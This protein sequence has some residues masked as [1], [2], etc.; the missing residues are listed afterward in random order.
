MRQHLLTPVAAAALLLS[1]AATAVAAEATVAE[2][3]KSR[4]RQ[5]L[6]ALIA[7]KADVNAP[8]A[9]G[10]TA[11]HWAVYQ[12]D[13]AMVADL[14]AAGAGVNATNDYGVAPLSLACTNRNA[15]VV[16]K[17]LAAGADPNAASQTGETA[18]M[19]CAYSGSAE[20]VRSL[21]QRG[22]DVNRRENLEQ[23]T[24][25]MWA[26]SQGHGDVV[27]ILL[28]AGADLKARTRVREHFV[29]Y[30]TQCGN[31]GFSR[32]IDDAQ[33]R[34]SRGGYAALHFAARQGDVESARLLVDAGAPIEE[35]AADGYTPL[36]LATHS[37][38]ATLTK[39][40]LERGANPNASGTGY[41]ALHTAVLRGDVGIVNDLIAAGA[42]VRSK[43]ARPSPTERFTDRWMT[44]SLS[45]VGYTPVQL[46]ARYLEVDCVRALL[47]AGADP[48]AAAPDGLTPLMLV[49]GANMNRNGSTDR[50]GRTVD[51]GFV[52]L[53]LGNEAGVL[54]AAEM[55]VKAGV[56]V[57]TVNEKTGDTALHGSAGLKM[58]KV[59]AYLVGLG[60]DPEARN[61]RAV[62]PRALLEGSADADAGL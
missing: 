42:D 14:L 61:K 50:R 48:N 6:Q 29:C 56:D 54:E 41:S 43:I 45:V 28:S 58:Q 40:F 62:S 33:A 13:D 21:V 44:L 17:L 59:Y 39:F 37:K 55:L 7:K 19:T 57:K 25:L 52:A 36:L 5:G 32:K 12:N 34:I 60:A 23:Q 15:P 30:T 10:T 16:T 18:L 53:L 4:D 24:A 47:A 38:H 27:G 26:A 49:T 51:P 31:T 11:L 9:D 3:V 22:A 46:A 20:A 35:V 1:A 2:A 8:L